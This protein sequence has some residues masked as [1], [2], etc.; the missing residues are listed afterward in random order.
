MAV[1][2]ALA[3]LAV[4]A[5]SS[6]A[7]SQPVSG[8]SPLKNP[9]TITIGDIA[10]SINVSCGRSRARGATFPVHAPD[11]TPGSAGTVTVDKE[12]FD[13]GPEGWHHSRA[14]STVALVFDSGSWLWRVNRGAPQEVANRLVEQSTA[15]P[16]PGDFV[17]ARQLLNSGWTEGAVWARLSTV[18]CAYGLTGDTR[19]VAVM[20]NLVNALSGR[21]YY[22]PPFHAVHNH[23]LFANLAIYNAGVVA[24][25][26]DW[27]GLAQSRM[28]DESALVF[29]PCGMIDEQASSYEV[30]NYELWLTAKAILGDSAPG[31]LT[32]SLDRARRAIGALVQPDGQ[33]QVIG[34]GSNRDL[35]ST[36]AYEGPLWCP[37]LADFQHGSGWAAGRTSFPGGMTQHTLRFGPIARMHGHDDHGAPTWWVELNGASTA[38]LSDRG[39][40][41]KSTGPREAFERGPKAHSVLEISNTQMPGGTTGHRT[42][43]ADGGYD[44]TLGWHGRVHDRTRTVDFSGTSASLEV[45]DSVTRVSRGSHY[46]VQHWQLAPGWSPRGSNTAVKGRL[47]LR[48]QCLV[49]GVDTPLIAVPV[50]QT[51]GFRQDLPAWD[52]Q[53]RTTKY[54]PT[55][56]ATTLRVS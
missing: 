50:R 17:P 49:N 47:T 4:A 9:S 15:S 52:M 46:Y 44:Y 3:S 35:G 22:G 54:G 40:F 5:L 37:T 32:E 30:K 23:G 6:P 25:N 51:T 13:V 16:D 1:G 53:C 36:Y 21:R 27:M 28:M 38:V 10:S 8:S 26:S 29:G 43:R 18:T 34:D 11:L 42:L 7:I 56:I 19:L 12:T 2:V 39:L 24:A 55:K 33:L 41:D 48:I 31:A 45:T 20:A 14:N